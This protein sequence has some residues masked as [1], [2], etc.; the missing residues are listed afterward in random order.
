MKHLKIIIAG[1]IIAF[2]SVVAVS[3]SQQVSANSPLN[4][5]CNQ[6]GAEEN[7][8]CRQR[9][10]DE[11]N[12]IQQIIQLL[13]FIVGA[14]AVVMIIWGGIRYAAS[15][16]NAAAVTAA[17]NTILYSVV[18]LVVAFLAYAIVNWIFMQI[19]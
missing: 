4:Q 2:F 12:L 8:V 5:I 7:E 3:P 1:A 19:R 16:G 10:D 18:G 17:K 9:N 15:G 11:S 14:V 13:L 6:T